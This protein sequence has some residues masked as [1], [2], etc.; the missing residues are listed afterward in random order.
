M[1][2]AQDLLKI[3][4]NASEGTR[5]PGFT[6]GGVSFSVNQAQNTITGNFTIPIDISVD[7][8]SGSVLLDA[9]DFLQA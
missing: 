2:P 1:T 8:V 5:K 9:K 4:V 3:L 7:P 6:A